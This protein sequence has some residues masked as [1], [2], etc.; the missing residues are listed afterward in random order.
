M[1]TFEP[2]AALADL[3]GSRSHC[4]TCKPVLDRH[5]PQPYQPQ[6][7]WQPFARMVLRAHYVHARLI[8]H[9]KKCRPLS[10]WARC[11]PSAFDLTSGLL[12]LWAVGDF[13][14]L[15]IKQTR[16]RSVAHW[17]LVSL[18]RV[19]DFRSR[20]L[21]RLSRLDFRKQTLHIAVRKRRA[22]AT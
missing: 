4:R 20:F 19:A 18:A 13:R 12:N 11:R 6:Y 2:S 8:G 14:P 16:G 22:E 1:E 9:P 10:L 7:T 17:R 3:Q 15:V 5:R 21:E